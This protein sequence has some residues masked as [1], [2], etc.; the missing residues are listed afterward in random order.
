MVRDLVLMGELL[1][2][3]NEGISAC[4]GRVFISLGQ[5]A[6]A[7]GYRGPVGGEQRRLARAS[8]N[9][10]VDST[11]VWRE[12]GR[13]DVIRELRWHLLEA[14]TTDYGASDGAGSARVALSRVTQ[15]LV[16]DGYLHYLKADVCRRLVQVDEVAAR[17]W[18]MLECERLRRPFHYYVFRAPIG[19]TPTPSRA[20]FISEVTGLDA[21]QNRRSVARRL[22]EAMRV[23]AEVD[24]RRYEMSLRRGREVGMYVLDVQSF[25]RPRPEAAAR[26]AAGSGT[27]VPRSGRER[28]QVA[29]GTQGGRERN[30][31]RAGEERSR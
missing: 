6:L 4:D 25:H 29:A 28:P 5:A 31:P 30:A 16:E 27:P 21:W 14:M 17:L 3:H 8:L 23:I 13:D 10:L 24:P 2:R 9:R 26:E 7:M 15:E 12:L 22:R 11:L 19:A 1:R 18:M 20:L